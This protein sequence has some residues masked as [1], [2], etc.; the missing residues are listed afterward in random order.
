LEHVS[1]G[2]KIC[3]NLVVVDKDL[4]KR[5]FAK[6]WSFFWKE[7]QHLPI[8]EGEKGRVGDKIWQ[9][10]YSIYSVEQNNC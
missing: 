7:E 9:N 1:L 5:C 3:C 8:M 6:I 4:Q 2:L 10:S